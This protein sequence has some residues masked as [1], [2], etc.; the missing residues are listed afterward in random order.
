MIDNNEEDWPVEKLYL[1]KSRHELWV[2]E[3]LSETT[4]NFKEAEKIAVASII[5]CAVSLCRLEDWQNWTSFALSPT[6]SWPEE[7]PHEV[8]EFR[9]KVI[10]AI[11]PVRLDE[12]KRSTETFSILLNLAAQ[13]FV[14][15]SIPDRG[16]LR[17]NK[18]YKSGGWNENYDADLARYNEWE[19]ECHRLLREATKAANWMAEIIRHEINPMFFAEKGK[20]LV[21]E[22]PFMDLSFRTS[23]LEF[24]DTEKEQLPASLDDK[25]E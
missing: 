20:F 9:Q 10:A 14:S 11:W 4:N 2:A 13:T 18:F 16:T 5:D 12:L 15:N 6:P 23:L 1:V 17:P 22:G 21:M 7:L 3:T 24:S 8:F 19:N 25:I